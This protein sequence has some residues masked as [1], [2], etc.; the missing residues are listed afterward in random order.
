MGGGDVFHGDSDFLMNVFSIDIVREFLRNDEGCQYQVVSVGNRNVE[1]SRMGI[2]WPGVKRPGIKRPGN[3]LPGYFRFQALPEYRPAIRNR[4]WG[5]G[6]FVRVNFMRG[7]GRI[8]GF[9][10]FLAC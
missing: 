7:F 5:I 4:E 6:Q 9:L 8:V 1:I 2:K 10:C 3:K